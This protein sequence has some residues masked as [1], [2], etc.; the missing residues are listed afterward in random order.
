LPS[1]L[2]LIPGKALPAGCTANDT[3]NTIFTCVVKSLDKNETQ[4]FDFPVYAPAPI[5]A[6]DM[7]VSAAVEVAGDVDTGNNTF[8]LHS[9]STNNSPDVSATVTGP[10]TLPVGTPATMT[11]TVSNSG[12]PG[13]GMAPAGSAGTVT[14]PPGVELIPGSLPEDCTANA[15]NTAFTCTV[16]NILNPGDDAS[17][18]FQVLA[19][20]PIGRVQLETDVTWPSIGGAEATSLPILR[21]LYSRQPSPIPTLAELALAL[22]ALAVAASATAQLRRRG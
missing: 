15:T 17:F 12:E 1:G 14:L 9:L 22:L 6:D 2:K 7:K 11:L 3:T 4:S 16:N 18:E 21:D 8:D 10:G 19:P 5:L 20:A 13:V